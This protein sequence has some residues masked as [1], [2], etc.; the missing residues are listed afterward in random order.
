VLILV[1]PLTAAAQPWESRCRWAIASVESAASEVYKNNKKN[2]KRFGMQ[3]DGTEFKG[4]GW[5]TSDDER[6]AS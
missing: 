1:L 4:F 3:F 2:L 5:M 6:D